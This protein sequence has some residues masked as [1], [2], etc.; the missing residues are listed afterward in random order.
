MSNVDGS[1]ILFSQWQQGRG[2]SAVFTNVSVSEP[3]PI[4]LIFVASTITRSRADEWVD[5]SSTHTIAT[6]QHCR[7]ACLLRVELS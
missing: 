5:S 6:I 7:D 1:K 4:S 3:S 2:A